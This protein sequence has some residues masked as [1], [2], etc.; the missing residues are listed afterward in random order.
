MFSRSPYLYYSADFPFLWDEIMLPIK[1]GSDYHL[2]REIIQKVAEETVGDYVRPES[3]VK[4]TIVK[5][6]EASACGSW[7]FRRWLGPVA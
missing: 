2:A 4:M 3:G 7:P 5:V 1:Y 6:G